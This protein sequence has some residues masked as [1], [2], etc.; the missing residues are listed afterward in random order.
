MAT[1]E[2]D[3]VI[4]SEDEVFVKAEDVFA[5]TKSLLEATNVEL[6]IN[7]KVLKKPLKTYSCSSCES[8]VLKRR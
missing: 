4:E 2:N 3:A 7:P 5:C 6:K 1:K 8:G